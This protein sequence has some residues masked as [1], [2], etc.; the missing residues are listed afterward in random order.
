[1]ARVTKNDFVDTGLWCLARL[2][3]RK[4]FYGPTNQV[5]P[6]ATVTRWVEALLKIPKATD[7]AASLARIT[8]DST[9]DLPP[10]TRDLV[11]RAFPEV[12]LEAGPEDNLAAMGRI[13]GEELPS[14][15]V[16]EG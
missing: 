12:N 13:F 6:P 15:L 8:G 10:T 7:A 2:G 3:A 5:L 14:G 1:M 9:R 16:F 4:L 11:R